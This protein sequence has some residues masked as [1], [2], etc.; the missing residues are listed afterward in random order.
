MKTTIAIALTAIFAQGVYAVSPPD[1]SYLTDYSVDEVVSNYSIGRRIIL[2]ADASVEDQGQVWGLWMDPR[3]VD[4]FEKATNTVVIY[5]DEDSHED[6]YLEALK[7]R[8]LPSVVHLSRG[9]MLQR[10]METFENAN[11]LLRWLR[12]AQSGKRWYDELYKRVA[13]NPDDL[14]WRFELIKELQNE[15]NA[16][17]ADRL[18][19]WLFTH[20]DLWKKYEEQRHRGKLN[21][22]EFKKVLF[23]EISRIREQ[24]NLFTSPVRLRRFDEV[25]TYEFDDWV[26]REQWKMRQITFMNGIGIDATMQRKLLPV[27]ERFIEARDSGTATDR[28]LFILHALTAEGEEWQAMVDHYAE[29]LP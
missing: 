2:A 12:N 19:A 4:Y 3:V 1:I 25:E 23:A 11:E 24:H 20:N 15:G 14:R 5:L 7:V 6:P 18:F 21:E 17:G 13:N 10:R 9:G 26:S 29:D 27:A 28:D 22:E 8:S 16:Y